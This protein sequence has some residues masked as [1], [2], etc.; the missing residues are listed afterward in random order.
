M[1]RRPGVGIAPSAAKPQDNNRGQGRVNFHRC[2]PL[3]AHKIGALG[4]ASAAMGAGP[5]GEAV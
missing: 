4:S 3:R 2:G 5:A 1:S